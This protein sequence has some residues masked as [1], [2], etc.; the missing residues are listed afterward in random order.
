MSAG[1]AH[2]AA[3]QALETH[4]KN[5]CNAVYLSEH[6][7]IYGRGAKSTERRLA[8]ARSRK[9]GLQVSAMLSA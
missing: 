1:P 8:A 9:G 3:L 7:R 2:R 5:I 6:E 4:C